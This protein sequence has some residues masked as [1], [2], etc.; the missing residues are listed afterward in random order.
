MS[1]KIFI[2]YRRMES[3]LSA[4]NLYDLLSARFDRQVLMDID[5]IALDDDFV[6][7]I[8]K[9][10]AECEVLI[11]VIGFDLFLKSWDEALS[12]KWVTD[13][14]RGVSGPVAMPRLPPGEQ[15]A[16]GAHEAHTPIARR[17]CL[18]LSFAL[19]P[20]LLLAALTPFFFPLVFNILGIKVS[21]KLRA[22]RRIDYR[23]IRAFRARGCPFR[24]SL[25]KA[26]SLL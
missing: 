23:N 1:G 16:G 18:W 8:E 24:S 20:D 14:S 22:A 3:R 21:S 13:S 11:A 17:A 26:A 5:S 25:A 2:S 12:Q 19:P 7:A 10:V 9:T 6:K 4:R 15:L